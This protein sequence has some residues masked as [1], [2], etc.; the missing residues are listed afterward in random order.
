MQMPMMAKDVFIARPLSPGSTVAVKPQAPGEII[1]GSQPAAHKRRILLN[2]S[3]DWD[4][5]TQPDR[6][7]CH[8][9]ALFEHH[10]RPFRATG[11]RSTM[12]KTK[13]QA[14]RERA[15]HA[16]LHGQYRS[17]GPAAILAAVLLAK[18]RSNANV[19]AKAAA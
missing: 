1:L 14:E 12:M 4:E 18:K 6:R 16:E 17:I 11:S 3:E 7:W 19:S 8:D 2:M 13:R 15:R 9:F 5:L 10:L